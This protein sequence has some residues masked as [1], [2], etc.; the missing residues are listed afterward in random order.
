MAAV[1]ARPTVKPDQVG[2][3]A[4]D[5]AR[6]AAEEAAG[7]IGVGEHLGVEADADRV[8]SHFFACPH[9]GYAGWRWSVT[10]V[11]ACPGQD[12]RR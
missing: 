11:R 9:A 12:R 8:V 7:A 5:L 1:G 2:A 6:E 10:L 4:V 3:D